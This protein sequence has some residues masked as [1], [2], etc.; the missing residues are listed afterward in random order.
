MIQKQ[1]YIMML[2]LNKYSK[3]ILIK[4]VILFIAIINIYNY[5]LILKI[6]FISMTK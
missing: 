2:R 4:I 6:F 1:I 5:K 3:L